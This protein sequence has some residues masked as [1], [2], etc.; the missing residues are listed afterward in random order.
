ML[1][2]NLGR[3]S[4]HC[5]P[6]NAMGFE[7][8]LFLF[9]FAV[10]FMSLLVLFVVVTRSGLCRRI[11]KTSKII[12]ITN[13]SF[14]GGEHAMLQFS[15]ALL[16]IRIKEKQPCSVLF[17]PPNDVHTKWFRDSTCDIRFSSYCRW[18]GFWWDYISISYITHTHT[19]ARA[20]K[21]TWLICS[22]GVKL[23]QTL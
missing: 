5:T 8:I 15:L 23:V 22:V 11:K 20:N 13:F 17:R 1:S 21:K 12:T 18:D 4:L 9:F 6:L 14:Y 10:V 7:W 2:S 16:I 3:C 19:Y